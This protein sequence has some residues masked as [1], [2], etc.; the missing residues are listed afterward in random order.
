MPS[1][2][3]T[4]A[5]DALALLVSSTAEVVQ[6]ATARRGVTAMG[7]AEAGG[8]VRVGLQPFNTPHDIDQLV[9]AVASL[10]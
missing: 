9:R 2:W 1:A 5:V 3:E 4:L 6:Y 8:A 7:I 10:G